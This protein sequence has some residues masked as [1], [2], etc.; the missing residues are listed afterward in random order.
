MLIIPAIDLIDG[1]VVRL[2]QGKGK[3]KIYSRDPVKTAKHWVRQGAEMLHVVDLD[4]AF[5]GKPANISVVKK[6]ASQVPV[7]V[8]FGGGV[9]SAQVIRAALDAGVERVV[10]GTKA[11]ESKDFLAAAFRNFRDRV[12]VSIDTK[13]GSLAVRGWKD[14]HKTQK[15]EAFAELLKD[16]GFKQFIYT[17]IL[18]D[19]MLEGPNIREIKRLLKETGMGMIASGGI[20]SLDDIRKL[21]NLEKSGLLGIIVGKA[22]YEGRF[23][24]SAALKLA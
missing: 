24:L 13:S 1:C 11:A 2:T 5:T 8:Q 19:G 15:A 23:T 9:R 7:P 4:G 20:S 14:A 16:I 3:E 17:D 10:L 21:K 18:K 22:L 12:V 6:I